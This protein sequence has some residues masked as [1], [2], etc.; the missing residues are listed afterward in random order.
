MYSVLI[1]SLR[2]D[3]KYQESSIEE[4]V[5]SIEKVIDDPFF[6]QTTIAIDIFDLT[7]SISLFRKNEKLLLRPAS[8]MKLLTSA[9]ALVNLGEDYFF[10]TDLFHTGVIEGSKLVRRYLCCWWLRS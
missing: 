6:E 3:S 1:Y 4:L 7:D 8:N 9:A 2:S 10:Q 5:P